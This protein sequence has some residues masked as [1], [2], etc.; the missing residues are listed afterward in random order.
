MKELISLIGFFFMLYGLVVIILT[1]IKL[2]FKKSWSFIFAWYDLW[3][4]L[5]WDKKKKWLYIFPFPMFGFVLL[6]E[7]RHCTNCKKP[8]TDE[9][10][11]TYE[12]CKECDSVGFFS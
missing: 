6:F 8:K 1:L 5:F 4:G 7:G 12:C 9:E 2:L 3:F 10:M 11:S